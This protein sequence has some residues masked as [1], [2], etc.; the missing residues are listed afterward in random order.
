MKKIFLFIFLLPIISGC[1][2][3]GIIGNHYASRANQ[4]ID[5]SLIGGK[6]D[7]ED[8]YYPNGNLEHLNDRKFRDNDIFFKSERRYNRLKYDIA[9]EYVGNYMKYLKVDAKE[10]EYGLANEVYG[11]KGEEILAKIENGTLQP[12]PMKGNILAMQVLQDEHNKIAFPDY[13]D[14]YLDIYEDNKEKEIQQHFDIISEDREYPE[15]M[16]YTDPRDR[17]LHKYLAFVDDLNE[18]NRKNFEEIKFE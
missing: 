5:G 14:E 11:L 12:Y 9:K 16:L 7:T 3:D 8:K 13:M 15:E 1:N 10:L 17:Y 4:P 6:F 2:G 18:E